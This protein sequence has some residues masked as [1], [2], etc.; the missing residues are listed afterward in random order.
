MDVVAHV[1]VDE[2]E[3]GAALQVR[4]VVERAGDE[5]VDHHHPVALGNEAIAQV[6]PDEPR[7][8]R[9]DDPHGYLPTLT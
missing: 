3:E 6:R 2:L 4:H 1:V 9:D 5:V 8:P 7:P